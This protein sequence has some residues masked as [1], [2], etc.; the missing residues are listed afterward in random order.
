MIKAWLIWLVFAAILVVAEMFTA[1][2]FLMWFGIAAAA[3]ALVALA[4]LP[5]FVQWGVFVGLSIVLFI[6]S[7]PLSEKLT[8]KQP[9]GIGADRLIGSQGIV[10]EA[11]NTQ[12]GKGMV[13]VR[14]DEWRAESE[15]GVSIGKDERVVVTRID[16][17]RL[18][19]RTI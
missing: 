16:G 8:R 13:R 19:V 2:F 11:I 6:F 17:T 18:I 1:G 3:A 4:G 10:T 7:R 9:A 14:G 12:E 15:S 5:Y